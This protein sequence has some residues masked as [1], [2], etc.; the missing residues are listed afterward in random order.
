MLSSFQLLFI[1]SGLA[2]SLSYGLNEDLPDKLLGTTAPMLCPPPHMPALESLLP[3]LNM[4]LQGSF[5]L[6][7]TY[8]TALMYYIVHMIISPLFF[9]SSIVLNPV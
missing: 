1:I 6:H 2:V 5:A 8:N 3:I 7:P 9:F 4:T